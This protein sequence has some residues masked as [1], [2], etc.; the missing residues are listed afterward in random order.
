MGTSFSCLRKP[1]TTNHATSSITIPSSTAHTDPFRLLDLPVEV[2]ARVIEFINSETLVSVRLTCK[3]LE[4][5][6]F[7]RFADEDFA[8]IYC[9]VVTVDDFKR[10]KGI[11]HESPRLSSKINSSR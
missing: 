6:T 10:L 4:D 9:W 11:L 2:V 7:D 8:H 5:I 1:K 3:A